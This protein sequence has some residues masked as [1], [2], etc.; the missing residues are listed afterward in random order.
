MKI[1]PI[2]SWQNGTEKEANDFNLETSFDNLKDQATFKYTISE[3]DVDN[4]IIY[5]LVN[6]SL[7]IEGA[8]YITWSSSTDANQWAYDWAAGQLN[9]V[10]IP[11]TV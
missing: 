2:T 11:E 10:L 9:L 7:N 3:M 5:T 1:Q 4:V 6:G 8:E